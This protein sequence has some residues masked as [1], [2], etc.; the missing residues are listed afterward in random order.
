MAH[1]MARA[2]AVDGWLGIM[3]VIDWKLGCAKGRGKIDNDGV[4]GACDSE[5]PPTKMGRSNT[6]RNSQSSPLLRD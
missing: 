3:I 4:D 2:D 6:P 5:S 1:G